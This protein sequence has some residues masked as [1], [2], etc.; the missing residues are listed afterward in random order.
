M[1][2]YDYKDFS[3]ELEDPVI[4]VQGDTYEKLWWGTYQFPA[5][6]YSYKGNIICTWS[7]GADSITAYEDGVEG[8]LYGGKISSDGGK[9]WTP[10]PRSERAKGVIM[11]NGKEY[12][13][14]DA[15]NSY[16]PDWLSKYTPVAVGPK[17]GTAIYAPDSVPEFPQKILPGEYDLQ[18]GETV[19]FEAEVNWP[20]FAM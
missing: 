8:T 6:K 7:T 1:N 10:R 16:V 2:K 17:S 12:V 13:P 14:T 19:R 9:T 18:T 4:V 11:S 5:L 20:H 3:L 15:K